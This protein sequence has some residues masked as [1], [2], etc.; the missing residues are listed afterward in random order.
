MTDRLATLRT[1]G[2][3]Y[4]SMK[5]FGPLLWRGF[6]A[7]ARVARLW[8]ALRGGNRPAAD[9]AALGLIGWGR[10]ATPAGDDLLAGAGTLTPW[11]AEQAAALA[12]GRTT[13]AGL[14]LL[15]AVARGLPPAPLAEVARAGDGVALA[16]AARR[17]CA[18]GGSSGT[19]ALVGLCL[20]LD[21]Q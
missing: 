7:D 5:G 2:L 20:A 6:E 1:E 18:I 13:A 21:S 12:P 10:G 14:A 15:E 3:A 11:L 17:L 9:G 19:D 16:Q 4:G 8:S